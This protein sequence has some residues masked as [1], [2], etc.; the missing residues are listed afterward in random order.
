M[1]AKPFVKWAGGK[2]KIVNKLTN[3]LP[4]NT[5]EL[6]IMNLSS[7]GELVF[8]NGMISSKALF[9]LM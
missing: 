5:K 4:H 3:F 2:S 1:K 9:Y 8:L 7:E 6:N